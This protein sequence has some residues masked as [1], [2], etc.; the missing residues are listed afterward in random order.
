MVVL[1]KLA[2]RCVGTKGL[3]YATARLQL[4]TWLD[5]RPLDTILDEIKTIKRVEVL[6][7]I[8]GVGANAE[9]Q[10][11]IRRQWQDYGGTIQPP[12]E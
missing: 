10:E 3:E 12:L 9:V 5:T 7:A 11:A 6:R 2:Q 8:L 1:E 4:K